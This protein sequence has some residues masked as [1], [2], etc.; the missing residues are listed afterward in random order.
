[1]MTLGQPGIGWWTWGLLTQGTLLQLPRSAQSR[2]LS[3]SFLSHPVSNVFGNLVDSFL[4]IYP[5]SHYLS[6]SPVPK[7][8][9]ATIP[10]SWIS[11]SLLP[12]FLLPPTL[13]VFLIQWPGGSFYFLHF[14]AVPCGM[15]GLSPPT[16]DL[17]CGPCIESLN[18]WTA[19]EVPKGD[20]LN[21]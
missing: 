17:T 8:S 6:A 19:R 5:Q 3:C 15:Q 18:H 13:S 10:Q 12:Q 9:R 2:V 20:R 14:L 1:M 7:S 21:M 16:R 11:M 4:K